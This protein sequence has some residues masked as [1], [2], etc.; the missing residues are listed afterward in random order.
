VERELRRSRIG[1][2]NV[3]VLTNSRRLRSLTLVKNYGRR[4]TETETMEREPDATTERTVR[5]QSKRQDGDDAPGKGTD[6]NE[7]ATRREVLRSGAALGV[8]TLGLEVGQIQ[9]ESDSSHEDHIPVPF[10]ALPTIDEPSEADRQLARRR[11]PKRAVPSEGPIPDYHYQEYE[12]V[13]VEVPTWALKATQ[14]RLEQ[15]QKHNPERDIDRTRVEEFL[16]EYICGDEEFV[17]SD[18]RDAVSVV[19]DT[20]TNRRER[21]YTDS[22]NGDSN[23]GD[24]IDT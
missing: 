16:I 4:P 18:G 21:L 14:W 2:A 6:D 13:E 17:T 24:T 10:N 5:D 23:G 7:G 9:A 11:L 3:A 19:L 20:V 15:Q 1:A 8:S 12:P 22:T